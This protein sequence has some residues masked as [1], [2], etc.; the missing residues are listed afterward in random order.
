MNYNT[1]Y[2]SL[3][4]TSKNS[5]LPLEHCINPH[6]DPPRN[7]VNY[8]AEEGEKHDVRNYTATI[9]TE[10]AQDLFKAESSEKLRKIRT[11]IRGMLI[12]FNAQPSLSYYYHDC[13][14]SCLVPT[15]DTLPKAL[16][17]KNMQ[18]SDINCQIETRGLNNV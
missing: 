16:L 13:S 8:L 17:N 10:L 4:T 1:R 3:P 5:T 6:S 11:Y 14:T 15:K 9:P 7:C 12:T 18:N 2:Q